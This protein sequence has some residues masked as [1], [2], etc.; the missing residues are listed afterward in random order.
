MVVHARF[1]EAA[2][3]VS[4][5]ELAVE[6]PVTRL[7][8]VTFGQ[9]NPVVVYRP[10]SGAVYSMVRNPWK[11]LA[12]AYSGY[13]HY[14]DYHRQGVRVLKSISQAELTLARGVPVLE[15]YFAT[16]LKR[17]VDVPDLADPE[18]VLEGRLLEAVRLAQD[19]GGL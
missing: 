1:A 6:N 14:N 2:T 13:R 5:Q 9:S 16:A 17:L 8:Q 7:E 12:G 3:A 18:P 4:A 10:N 11:V 15:A 19:V